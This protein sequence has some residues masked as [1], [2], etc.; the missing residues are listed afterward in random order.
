MKCRIC[1]RE[2]LPG[3]TLCRDCTAARKRAFAATVTQPLLAA[4]G[5]RGFAQPRFAPRPAAP[6]RARKVRWSL[7]ARFEAAMGIPPRDSIPAVPR[8][9]LGVQWLWFGVA[10]ATVIV[11]VAI[12]IVASNHGESTSEALTAEDS[13]SGAVAPTAPRMPPR[14]PQRA[15]QQSAT[16]QRATQQSATQPTPRRKRPC[17]NHAY[18]SLPPRSSCPSRRS[19]QRQSMRRRY[20]CRPIRRRRPSR[21]RGIPGK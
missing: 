19:R 16:Q 1:T 3:A 15:T 13:A 4:V 17:P 11:Y 14:R 10:I 2:C 20:R 5:V 21:C 9:R 7:V 8:R 18:A 12:R 6:R